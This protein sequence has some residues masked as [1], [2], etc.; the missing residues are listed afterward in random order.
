MRLPPSSSAAL[1]VVGGMQPS[2]AVCATSSGRR[3]R[4]S[5]D[6]ITGIAE[7]VGRLL[8]ELPPT[9]NMDALAGILGVSD[10]ST[11]NLDWRDLLSWRPVTEDELI[12]RGEEAA[13]TAL[14]DFT[15]P[16][17]MAQ[18]YERY[19]ANQA[20]QNYKVTDLQPQATESGVPEVMAIVYVGENNVFQEQRILFRM[21]NNVWLRAS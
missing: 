14:Y 21:V 10:L 6:E 11:A 5:A 17:V 18:A 9:A 4:L 20:P 7:Y 15:N 1:A 2:W 19:N 13:W 12:S 8:T 3:I 16:D